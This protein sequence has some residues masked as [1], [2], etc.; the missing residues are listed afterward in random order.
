MQRQQ[1]NAA[2]ARRDQANAL[3]PIQ[4]EGID[5]NDPNDAFV[6]AMALVGETDYLVI[7]DRCAATEQY[8][9]HAHRHADGLL[10]QDDATLDAD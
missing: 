6:L 3:N 9:S 2:P 10:C 8:R 4:P 7:G 1:H 5:T